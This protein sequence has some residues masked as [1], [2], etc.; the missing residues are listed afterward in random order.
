MISFHIGVQM[1][2]LQQLTEQMESLSRH[3]R[4]ISVAGV[5][6]KPSNYTER[7][8]ALIELSKMLD[9][10]LEMHLGRKEIDATSFGTVGKTYLV[11][12]WTLRAT[13]HRGGGND[14]FVIPP[15]DPEKVFDLIIKELAG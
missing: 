14:E 10:E 4:A 6:M 15:D 7:M 8:T 1:A 9:W 3:L 13:G 11:G 5:G 2:E 12:E